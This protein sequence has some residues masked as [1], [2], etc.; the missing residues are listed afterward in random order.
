MKIRP[1][2]FSFTRPSPHST[3]SP[4]STDR[5][6]ACPASIKLSEGIQETTSV[7]AEAGTKAHQVCEDYANHHFFD[8]EL[9]DAIK[10]ST[11]KEFENAQ[12]WVNVIKAWLDHPDIGRLLYFDLE[13]GLPIFPALGCFGTADALIIG[14]KGAAVIDY[15]NGTGHSVGAASPQLRTYLVSLINYID[16]M[17]ED[18]KFNTV[19]YQPNLDDIPKEAF[20]TKQEIAYHGELIKE[21]IIKADLKTAPVLGSH[22]HW[23]PAKRTSDPS[24]KCPALKQ[25]DLDVANTRFDEYLKDITVQPEFGS[26]VSGY[27]MDKRDQALLKL[28]SIMPLMKQIVD[29]AEDEFIHRIKRGEEIP[30]LT[31]GQSL[32]NR[33]WALDEKDI[34]KTLTSLGLEPMTQPAPRIKTVPE[35]EKEL[36]K[37]KFSEHGAMVKRPS[38]PKLILREETKN[39]FIEAL[40]NSAKAIV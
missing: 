18:Y 38:K 33:T 15:K 2:F 19:I 11:E 21:A 25:R 9:T 31:M 16:E 36:G 32:G 24:K 12:G 39:D 37:K 1:E 13:V 14:T 4:S 27:T 8:T 40:S 28:M 23:C 10:Y 17:P 34:V 30:G 6:M 35:V 3:F 5:W 29:D 7:Y 20:Y 26:L 22:C